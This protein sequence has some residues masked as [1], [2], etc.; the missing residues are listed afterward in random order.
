[1]VMM[2]MVMAMTYSMTLPTC[3]LDPVTC[4]ITMVYI[5]FKPLGCISMQGVEW[6]L[7]LSHIVLDYS[8]IEA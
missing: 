6:S 8:V 2:A 7:C 3:N 1:M 5:A 4:L